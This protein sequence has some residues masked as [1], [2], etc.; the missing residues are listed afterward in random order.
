MT[1]LISRDALK[2]A[3]DAGTVTVVD[4]LGGDYYAKQHLPA[5]VALAPGDVHRPARQ[6]RRHRHLLHRAVLP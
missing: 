2:A 4:A 1:A 6:E 3:I 5:A